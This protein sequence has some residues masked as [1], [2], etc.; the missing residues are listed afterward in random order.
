MEFNTTKGI[1]ID[2]SLFE[3]KKRNKKSENVVE[4]IPKIPKKRVITT[5]KNWN[6]ETHELLPE[7]QLQYV[8]QVYDNNIIDIN[9]CKFIKQQLQQKLNGYRS[10]DLKKNKYEKE[11]FITPE[12]VLK[13]MLEMENFCFYCKKRVHVLYENV[14]EPIQWTLERIDNE[15]GHNKE[16]VVIACLNCNLHRKTMHYERYLFTKELNIIKTENS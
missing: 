10:Q 12:E 15:K 1:S 6:F 13:L 3:K 2:S 8:L 4:I 11:S 9:P 14:R 7:K 16:N 5:T